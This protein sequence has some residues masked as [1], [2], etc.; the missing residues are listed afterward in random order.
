[1]HYFNDKKQILALENLHSKELMHTDLK[2][3]KFAIGN[4]DQSNKLFL[5][6]LDFCERVSIPKL[7]RSKS[8]TPRKLRINENMFS[9]LN[10]HTGE[11]LRAKRIR[12]VNFVIAISFRDD[13]ESLS[14]IVI[15]LFTGGKFFKNVPYELGN[16]KKSRDALVSLK[17][18]ILSEIL[19]SGIPRI[20]LF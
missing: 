12:I 9:S 4:G 16:P 1:L 13:L 6:G 15:Y 11:G 7:N 8:G 10:I 2:P 20:V 18:N 5:L 17:T 3:S 19:L 14:Y